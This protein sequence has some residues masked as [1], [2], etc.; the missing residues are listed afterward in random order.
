ML[1]DIRLGKRLCNFLGFE[2]I[3]SGVGLEYKTSSTPKDG[4]YSLVDA[5]L[6]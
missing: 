6:Q 1:S 2:I 3:A 5:I 4:F